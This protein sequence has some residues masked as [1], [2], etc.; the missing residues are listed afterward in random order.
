MNKSIGSIVSASAIELYAQRASEGMVH[1]MAYYGN[2]CPAQGDGFVATPA[3]YA[4]MLGNVLMDR[5]D[6][7]DKAKARVAEAG[8]TEWWAWIWLAYAEEL[9]AA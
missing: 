7:L 2:V 5:G 6:T 9:L 8:R 3:Y 1:S 4:N